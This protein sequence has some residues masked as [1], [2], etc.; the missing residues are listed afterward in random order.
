MRHLLQAGLKC[1]L[2]LSLLFAAVFMGGWS[3]PVVDLTVSNLEVTQGIQ[4]PTNTIQLIARRSTAVRATIGVSGTGASV[5]NVTGRL[6][7]FVSGSEITP[8]AGLAPINAPLTAPLAP[9]RA[10]ENDTLNFELIAPTNITASANVRFHVDITP[11]AGETN[12]GNNSGEVTLSVVNRSVPL[13]F[14]TRINYTPSGLG[15]PSDAFIQPG[16]GDAFLRGIY[17]VNDG[18]PNLYRQGL[19]PS[20][21]YSEDAS[22]NHIVDTGILDP[23]VTSDGDD[24][25]SL[26]ASCRQL[27][28]DSGFGPS[29]KVFLYGWLA[30]NPIDGNGLSTTPGNNGFGNTDVTRGQRTL[31]HEFGHLLGLDHNGDNIDQVGWDVGGRLA[32]NPAGNNVVGRV[33]RTTLFD[34]MVAGL[35]S[36][37]A[38]V[39]TGN[40][41]FFLG[42]AALASLSGADSDADNAALAFTNN[43]SFSNH[44][45]ENQTQENRRGFSRRVAVIQGIFDPS[46]ERLLRLEPVFRFPWP[47]RP[48]PQPRTGR[49]VA[50]ILDSAG[51]VTQTVFDAFLSEDSGK[52]H[53]PV[54]GFFEVM[55]PVNPDREIVSV[56]ITDNRGRR[57]YGAFKRSR[58]PQVRIISPANGE[59]LG[60]KTRVVWDARDPDTPVNQLVFQVAYSPNGGSTWVPVAVDVQGKEATFDSTQVQRSRGNG[61]IRV[62]V[63]DGLNTAFA[64]VGKL[65]TLYAKY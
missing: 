36:N 29:E 3:K 31:A 19:F 24:L 23:T 61:M 54:R 56:R 13:I 53:A 59:R 17:P 44:A 4:T 55:V 12:T 43:D 49:F 20:L 14:F 25:L 41:N 46:G 35:L 7:V 63:S 22:N 33:R 64:D 47:S 8:A 58:P 57:E 60:Q 11:V 1:F 2:F 45:E 48:T 9:S 28:V 52:R 51:V 6:H 50:E 34:I 21:D 30:G 5:P 15:L 65:T 38:W 37:Q 42:S 26:L 16:R 10:N 18:D 32:N 62:F 40:Y 27:I 39:K